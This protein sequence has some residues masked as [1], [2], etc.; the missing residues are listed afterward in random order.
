M[1]RRP[2][3]TRAIL[4]GVGL[5]A[6][7]AAVALPA[8]AASPSPSAGSAAASP[9]PSREPKASKEPKAVKAAKAPEVAVTLRGPVAAVKDANGRTTY[10]LTA[11]GKTVRLDAGPAW[12]F[13][14]KHPLAPFV[15]K[16]VTI[17]GGQRGDEVDVATVDGVRLRA[18]GKPP[19]AGGWK[20][21]GSAHP[22]WSQ[23]KADRWAQK[24]AT[25]AGTGAAGASGSGCWP[26]GHCK[27]PAGSAAPS[28]G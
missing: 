12:F 20:A 4:L 24:Q 11:N 9:A 23:E 6:L 5:I 8:L 10:T 2:G 21:V 7:V 28:G 15:G 16:T 17:T 1:T 14:D 13:G 27:A 18:A 22:G 19:W 25:K 26:P 3:P